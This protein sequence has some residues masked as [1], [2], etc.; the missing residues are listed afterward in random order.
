MSR[1]LMLGVLACAVMAATVQVA[2]AQLI[3]GVAHRNSS[4]PED[5][6]I[7][8]NLLDEGALTFVD[9][10]HV[11][12]DVPES[13]I[14]AEYVMVAN[15][16]KGTSAYELDVT[17][18]QNATLYVFVDN[19]MGGSAGGLDVAPNVDGMPWL[20]S[21]GFVDTDIDIGIDESADGSI[22]Q[23]Y[24]VFALDVKAGTVTIGGDT[25]GH[26]G[27][28]Y[29]V[30]VVSRG[31]PE[32]AT[33]PSPDNEAVDVPRETTLAWE[34]GEGVTAHDVYLG[35]SF[36]D[37][38][39]ASRANP[40][41]LLL[42]QGQADLTFDT[43][44]L[45]L[46]QTY[47]WRIDE[48]LAAGGIFQ[49]EV[50]SFTVEPLAYAI[51]G[52][53]ATSNATSDPGTGPERT[54]DGSGINESDQHSAESTDMWLGK[55]GAEP[56]WL[57]YEFDR[58]YKLH[59]ML[60][61]NY[62]VSFEPLLGF[63]LKDVTIEF[64][65]D[66]FEWTVLGDV[67]LAQAAGQADYVANTVVDFGGAAARTVRI[68]VNSNR[69]DGSQLG[70]SEVRFLQ[71]PA[72]PREPEPASDAAG[73]GVNPVLTWRVGR[74]AASHDVLF[75]TEQDALAVVDSVSEAAFVPGALDYGLTYY[76]R[77]DEVNEAEPTSVWEGDLWSFMTQEFMVVDDFEGYTDDIDAGG[78][79][80]LTWIDGYEMDGNGSTVGNIEAPFA[81]QTI[82]NSGVQSMPLF[83]DNA[84]ASSAEAELALA[85]NW[86][87]NGIKSLSLY[88]HGAADNTGQLYVKINGTKVLYDGDGADI[89]SAA[90][91]P[92]NIDLS[93]VGGNLSSVTSLIIGI[94][95]AGA[96][97]VLY[98]D[99]VRLYPLTPE[100]IM[101]VE[102]DSAALLAH[103]EFEGNANDSSGNG[104]DGAITDGQLV[105]PGKLGEGMAVQL[106][107][108]GYVDLGNP[109]MLDFGTGDW[110]LTAWFKTAMTGTGDANKGT[111]V[112]KGGD[113]GGGHRYALILSETTE[114]VVALVTDDNST[115]HVVNS[116]SV[117]NDD[118][119][120]CAV[121]Q[122]AGTA[123]QI[124]IDGQLEG[125]ATA[126][127]DYDLSG[128]SQHNAYVGAI[129]NNGDGSLYKLFNGLIDDVRIYNSA[130]SAGEILW[131]AGKTAPKHKAF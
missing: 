18:S 126:A 58:L 49:G 110:T 46:G 115:K 36:D 1:K 42:S 30:A 89:A 14:G 71:I 47:Y 57:Q 33:T 93:A 88:F 92:W 35:V 122:R 59:E 53:I 52:I 43:S 68:T 73:V 84:A 107:A 120:H 79:I 23:Y 104:L 40:M 63:G 32:A 131:L 39:T 65:A 108:A 11:Y 90:W 114:G 91:Q 19:R 102:P 37:V 117:V 9:R 24:S 10:T 61:W 118:E 111:L 31:A 20:E 123:V 41:D 5:P 26:A 76:W 48:V 45:E 8:P 28:M 127:A 54:V 12:A 112:G 95:G 34:P 113:S 67:E 38:N 106:S 25:E 29:G 21:M 82:V 125:T 70:L 94:E 128:T 77:I 4:A 75:G 69:H 99:D 109:P 7:A 83:Y 55:A 101:P 130:L 51:E 56:V 103:Y 98:I 22:N 16:N 2:Q 96:A 74:G 62:N 78:A 72:F 50:W 97:G 17:L 85:Q 105:S 15:D 13:L 64:S 80:F 124:F 86:T 60:V 119:W 100:L 44:R 3:T 121:G 6:E 66:G 129:T 116:A 81:E 27:N 87:T